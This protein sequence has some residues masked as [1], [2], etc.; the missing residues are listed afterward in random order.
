MNSARY[1]TSAYV[2]ALSLVACSSI[3][4]Y[5]IMTTLI[6]TQE[7]NA[8]LIN[9]AGR[10]RR[11]SQQIALNCLRLTESRGVA[12]SQSC[13]KHLARAIDLMASSHSALSTGSHDQGLPGKVSA[14]IKSIYF[15]APTK[16]DWQVENYLDHARRILKQDSLSRDDA[17]LEYI[18]ITG[19]TTLVDSLD[20]LVKQYELDSNAEIKD[21]QRMELYTLI[22]TLTLLTAEAFLIF[23]PMSAKINKQ[24]QELIDSQKELKAVFN[25]VGE[26]LLTMDG[27][28]SIV[29]A[30]D[31]VQ[32]L[33]GHGKSDLIGKSLT[34]L[35]CKNDGPIAVHD[36]EIYGKRMEMNCVAKDGREFPVEL[37]ITKTALSDR[38][39]FTLSARDIS[40]LKRAEK[41]VSEFYSVVSHELRTPL[42]AI[43][44]ALGLM[45]G[46][47]VG[48]LSEETKEFVSI[49]RVEADRMTRLVNDILDLRKIA[50]GRLDLKLTQCDLAELAKES[51][52]A[53]H[54]MLNEAQVKV[55][56]NLQA[57]CVTYCDRDRIIQ[58][59][60]NL[61]SNAI[62]FS[63][64]ESTIRV[65][66][67][68]TETNYYRIAVQDQGPGIA[69][70]KQ[71]KLFQM[72]LQ[73][74][75]SDVRKKGGSGLGLAISKA[76]VEQHG[77]RI[78]VISAEGAGAKFWFDLPIKSAPL[79]QNESVPSTS[80]N[81][82]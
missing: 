21:I 6:K 7:A 64:H 33:W 43:R 81:K 20:A 40:A 60:E 78:G 45:E 23:R 32:I 53:V 34:D 79:V 19:P 8:T 5:F 77:G 57:D 17:D 62:K 10:Q 59:I 47:M 68:A 61:L 67:K 12:E 2:F 71:E 11:L 46:G 3:C 1:L 36:A 25:T 55:E 49:A 9:I 14:A 26:A 29:T 52:N 74:D 70:D 15:E 75:S 66:V 22:F 31:Q 72:F 48:E 39:L 24:M 58:I 38:E 56:T 63:P 76:L 27:Q 80:K 13:K 16:L 82:K 18:L 30:N 28:S 35:F 42:T 69:E 37:V 44:G 51:I 65:T 50:A 41:Q 73:L 4:A 54:T